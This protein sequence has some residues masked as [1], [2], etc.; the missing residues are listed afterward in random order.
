MK[1]PPPV[2]YLHTR[3]GFNIKVEAPKKAPIISSE[4]SYRDM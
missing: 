3:G 4:A 2:N 1:K